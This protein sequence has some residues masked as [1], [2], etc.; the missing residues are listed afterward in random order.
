MPV[1]IKNFPELEDY[2]IWSVTDT[3]GF[4]GKL[5]WLGL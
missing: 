1:V 3:V 5:E 4:Q 2:V